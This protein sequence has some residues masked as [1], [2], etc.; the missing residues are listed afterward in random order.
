M[1][2]GKMNIKIFKMKNRRGYAAVCNGCLTEG[3]T[4]IQAYERMEK[5]IRRVNRKIEK[6]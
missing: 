4:K 5:A 2:I 6:H 1:K 3:S